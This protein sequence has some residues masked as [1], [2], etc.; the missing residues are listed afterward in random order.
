MFSL[1]SYPGPAILIVKTYV[2]LNLVCKYLH[3]LPTKPTDRTF[4]VH[5][6]MSYFSIPS[7]NQGNFTDIVKNLLTVRLNKGIDLVSISKYIC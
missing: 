5:N 2:F 1:L 6:V 7:K 4:H 3:Y